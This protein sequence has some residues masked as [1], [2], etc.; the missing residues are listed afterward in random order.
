MP[1]A[2]AQHDARDYRQDFPDFTPT[3]YLNCAYQGVFPNATVARIQESCELKRH[4]ERL[5]ENDYFDL[6]ERVRAIFARLI[7]AQPEEVALTTSATQGIG[8]VA[9]GFDFQPGDEV[10]VASTNFPSNFFTW[11]HLRRRGVRVIVLE[12]REGYLRLDDVRAVL[13]SRTRILALDWVSYTTGVRIDLGAF[14]DL[15]HGHGARFVVDATQGVGALELKVR[16]LPVD[17]LA[18]AGYKWLLGPYGVG[19]AYVSAET[20]DRLDLQVVNWLSAEGSDDFD[21]LP[22]KEVILPRAA[23]I[24]DAGETANFLNLHA[25]EASLEYV[26]QAGVASVTCHC[27]R[28]IDRLIEGLRQRGLVLSSAA[29]PERRSTILGFQGESLEAT[30]M[31]HKRL[32][33]ES[34]SVSLRQGIIRVSPYLYNTEADVGRLLAALGRA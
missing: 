14:G 7:G 18:V 29:D 27:H 20:Q 1:Q 5:T 9:T 3:T 13:N 10:V 32:E 17:V 8:I 4:P 22:E 12:P 25:T 2:A 11:L 31:L 30:Q 33:R 21:S 19:F 26:E 24:F 34:V 15:A 28:L 6:P 16:H 23:R